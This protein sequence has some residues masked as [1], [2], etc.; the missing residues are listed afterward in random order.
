MTSFGKL[1]KKNVYYV[2]ALSNDTV[3]MERLLHTL[4]SQ[5]DVANTYLVIVDMGRARE[6][7]DL[8]KYHLRIKVDYIH[9]GE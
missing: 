3:Y 4:D 8:N 7:F 6:K 5:Q 2:T 9:L 1:K